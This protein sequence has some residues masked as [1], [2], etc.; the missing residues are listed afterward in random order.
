[1]IVVIIVVTV[2]FV[3]A[4]LSVNKSYAY[5]VAYAAFLA[6]VAFVSMFL[7][8]GCSA[9][10]MPQQVEEK[11]ALHMPLFWEE[12]ISD[13]MHDFNDISFSQR[14]YYYMWRADNLTADE[15]T[16]RNTALN[17]NTGVIPI[18]IMLQ[19]DGSIFA[20]SAVKTAAET[21]A[22]LNR[23][24]T[25]AYSRIIFMIDSLGYQLLDTQISVYDADKDIFKGR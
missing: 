13:L 11:S 15:I 9:D 16:A 24:N 4:V 21:A 19:P 8:T 10:V 6:V 22:E 17:R 23:V 5:R 2:V 7:L 12:D 18:C 3:W 25:N 14:A 1:M 20:L